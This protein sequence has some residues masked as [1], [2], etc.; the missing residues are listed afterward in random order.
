MKTGKLS[1]DRSFLFIVTYGRSGS[2]LV[3]GVLNSIPDFSICGE[4]L[5]ALSDLYEFYR[6]YYNSINTFRSNS[7]P[8]DSRNSWY[9]VISN[10][11][12]KGACSNLL[13]DLTSKDVFDRVA[14]FKEIRWKRHMKGDRLSKYLDWLNI[15]FSPARF[16]FLTRDLD[17]TCRSKWHAGNPTCKKDLQAF[18]A[19]IHDYMSKHSYQSWF[20]LDIGKL[21]GGVN[22]ERF[23]ELFGWLGEDWD[24]KKIQD[25]L[26]VRW[27][28]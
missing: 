13:W 28:Y 12:L 25:V 19:Y 15:V 11:G 21:H 18:E 9:Q 14:G 20:H 23:M 3:Q 4:N 5:D 8:V 16:I 6:K 10:E 24:R 26:D 1:Q 22:P 2:T 27:G 17:E 7:M